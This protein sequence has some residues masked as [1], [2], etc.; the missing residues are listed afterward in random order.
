MQSSQYFVFRGQ[1]TKMYSDCHT[2]EGRI[3]RCLSISLRKSVEFIT[4]LQ[5]LALPLCIG[6]SFLLHSLQCK[7]KFPYNDQDMLAN[8][9][10]MAALQTV[11]SFSL[12]PPKKVKYQFFSQYLAMIFQGYFRANSHQPLQCS[13][14]GSLQCP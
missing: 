10:K 1:T 5:I 2:L 8:L 12:Y 13:P 4:P 6:I 9:K 11:N 3:T 14:G 7:I